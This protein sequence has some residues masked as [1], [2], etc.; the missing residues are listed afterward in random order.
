MRFFSGRR[1]NARPQFAEHILTMNLALTAV[2][3]GV[4][5]GRSGP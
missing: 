1:L 2:R 3:T 4:S 5:A